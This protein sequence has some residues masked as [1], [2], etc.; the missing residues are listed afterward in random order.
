MNH[1]C[2]R[3]GSIYFLLNEEATQN[4]GESVPHGTTSMMSSSFHCVMA[5]DTA[6]SQILR[7]GL[8]SEVL[9]TCCAQ[10]DHHEL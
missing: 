1:I 10:T 5:S 8:F 9:N 4:N 2:K 6:S 7:L 3:T